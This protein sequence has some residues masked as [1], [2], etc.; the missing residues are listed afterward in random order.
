MSSYAVFL[1]CLSE[2]S[3]EGY[4]IQLSTGLIDAHIS[5]HLTFSQGSF[6]APSQSNSRVKAPPPQH[7][8]PN[9]RFYGRTEAVR[10]PVRDCGG[11]VEEVWWG[12]GYFFSQGGTL[13]LWW[14]CSQHEVS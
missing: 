4:G 14:G 6:L 9:L 3:L 1:A 7:T 13:S 10:S 2:L 8:L 12:Y 5:S 11:I